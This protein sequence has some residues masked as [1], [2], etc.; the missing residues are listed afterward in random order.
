L[1]HSCFRIQHYAGKVGMRN[2]LYIYWET[3]WDPG[4]GSIPFQF[5][6]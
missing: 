4:L 3:V 1:P 2:T 6:K 5:R